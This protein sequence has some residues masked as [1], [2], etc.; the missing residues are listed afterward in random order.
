MIFY[1][2]YIYSANFIAKFRWESGFLRGSMDPLA[3]NRSESTLVI[4]CVVKLCELHG[5]REREEVGNVNCM[6]RE[7]VGRAQFSLPTPTYV[8]VACIQHKC[9][10]I[11]YEQTSFKITSRGVYTSAYP[12]GAKGVRTPWVWGGFF[13]FFLFFHLFYNFFFKF[14]F[15]QNF[16]TTFFHFFFFKGR[17]RLGWGKMCFRIQGYFFVA[18]I[19]WK[20]KKNYCVDYYDVRRTEQASCSSMINI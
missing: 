5:E 18:R 20:M 3:T 11:I 17:G 9:Y 12:G 19:C 4:C 6:E 10:H 13:F 1:S 7:E 15:K 8:N 14:Y 2:A 16:I